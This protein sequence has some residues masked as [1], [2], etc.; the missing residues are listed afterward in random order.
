VTRRHLVL[1]AI[2]LVAISSSAVLVRLADAPAF[3][4][5]F[6]RCFLAALVLVPIGLLR[7]RDEYRSLDGSMWRL[8]ALS[9]LFLG[10]HFATWIPSITMT[11]VA[12]SVVLVQTQPIWVALLGP[13][14]G[15]RMARGALVGVAIALVGTVV[16]SGGDFALGG[17]ALMGDLL[18]LTG[19]VLVAGYTILGRKVRQQVSVVTYSG[20]V[21]TVAACVLAAVML[22]SG[23]PFLGYPAETWFFFVVITIGP[24]FLG[25]T[26]FN[27]LLG[28]LSAAVVAVVLMLEPIGAALLAYIFLGEVPPG[29]T[30]VGGVLILAGV[31]VAVR[32]ETRDAAA[33]VG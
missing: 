4:I 12:A 15:E 30:L 14:F 17:E 24:Q 3:A 23:T 18:A 32:A 16:I 9:G 10:G 21:Y 19:A 26:M 28:E 5:A 22:V 31:L 20:I 1:V 29:A 11:T 6:Y 33:P 27:Y 7:F 13:I 25:H 2:G 8:A